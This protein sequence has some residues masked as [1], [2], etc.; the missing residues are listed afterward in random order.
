MSVTI[1]SNT[2]RNYRWTDWKAIVTIKNIARPQFDDDGAVYTIWGYDGPEV[3]MCQIWKGE[4]PY[5]ITGYTQVQN[6]SDKSDFET[7]YKS[8]YN[9]SL[10]PR[11]SDGV[12][13]I[14]ITNALTAPISVIAVPT[15]VPADGT[16]VGTVKYDNVNG[17]TDEVY[18]IPN[19]KT[20]IIQNLIGGAEV[21]GQGSVVELWYDPNGNKNGMII[22]DAVHTS[23]ESMQHGLCVSFVGNGTRRI[24]MRRRRLGGGSCEIFGRWEGYY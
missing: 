15:S 22:I 5:S 4:L 12:P 11:T 24:V 6:D 9:Q 1:G 17:A 16:K 19:N 18:T 3:H 21:T 10:E 14:D 2:Y 7:N 20:L 23:G 13:R 8:N